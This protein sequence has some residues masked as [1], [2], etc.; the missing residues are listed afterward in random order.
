MSLYLLDPSIY[1]N[2]NAAF[3]SKVSEMNQTFYPHISVQ[4]RLALDLVGLVRSAYVKADFLIFRV[5]GI[6]DVNL[7]DVKK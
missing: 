1:V 7:L 3:F 6:L 4:V 5:V 2:D